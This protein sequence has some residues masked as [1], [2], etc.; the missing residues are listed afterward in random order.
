MTEPN[1]ASPLG[2]LEGLRVL[3]LAGPMGAYCGKL[4]ADLGADVILVEPLDGTPIRRLGPFYE[5]DP[6]PEHSL[7]HWHF[8]TNK[9]GVTLDLSKR[10]GQELLRSLARNADVLLDTY[11]SGYLATLGLGYEDLARLNPRIIMTSITPFGQSGPYRDFLGEELIGQAAGGLLWMCGWPDRPP[12][13]MGGWPAM[14]QA[15][16]EA[17]GATLIAEYAREETG[18]G[19]HV[20]VAVQSC[21]PLS[22]MASM[23][24]YFVTGSQRQPRVGDGHRSA[25]NGM[26]ACSD[27]YADIRFRG[28]PGQWA[29]IVEWLKSEGMVEDLEDEKYRD[30]QTRLQEEVYRHIDEVFQR[31]IIR[32]PKE[33]A[34]DITQRKGLETGAVHTAEDIV[35]DPQLEARNFFVE[36]EHKELGRSFTYPGGPY[37]LAETPWRLRRRAPLL[38]EHNREIYGT[39]LGLSAGELATLR[40]AHVI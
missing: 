31:F 30:P 38:G 29:A 19:Q 39:E 36:L 11:A 12:V 23:P 8:N 25:L 15:S 28:R 3:D 20:D 7:W 16:G 35:N 14:H 18:V 37:T 26:F 32:Y 10:D 17:A 2:A 4:L 27:G 5:D 33:E 1:G 6:N 13:M 9:R 40:A 34:V 22:L 24:E 21:V